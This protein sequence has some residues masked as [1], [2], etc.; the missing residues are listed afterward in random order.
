MTDAL[1]LQ[2]EN[3]RLEALA[4]SAEGP[5]MASI[6]AP[7]LN[8]GIKFEFVQYINMYGP[9]PDGKFDPVILEQIRQ[10]L[11]TGGGPFAV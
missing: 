8:L 4:R 2:F 10:D 7:S 9:P 5:I 6:T 11:L 3:L 1:K